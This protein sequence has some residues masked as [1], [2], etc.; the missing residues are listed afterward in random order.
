MY[1]YMSCFRRCKTTEVTLCS[2]FKNDANQI[3]QYSCYL[4]LYF[5]LC[6]FLYYYLF[7]HFVFNAQIVLQCSLRCCALITV[8][9]S[10]VILG[11]LFIRH[12]RKITRGL[13]MC[14]RSR[15]A[16]W[17]VQTTFHAQNTIIDNEM[18]SVLGCKR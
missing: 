4:F 11:I 3:R 15:T 1:V 13:T 12:P 14:A 18:F 6:Y 7:Y 16:L 9:R 2:I 8:S 10:E 17:Y 5:I